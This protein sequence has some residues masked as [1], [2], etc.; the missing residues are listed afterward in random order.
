MKKKPVFLLLLAISLLFQ[1]CGDIEDYLSLIM[2]IEAKYSILEA[3]RCGDLDTVKTILAKNPDFVNKRDEFGYT[4][5]F[6]AAQS[7]HFELVKFLIARGADLNAKTED[8]ET[9]LHFL[10]FGES[11]EIDYIEIAKFIIEKGADIKIKDDKG[12]TLLHIA[13]YFDLDFDFIKLLI[14]KGADINARSKDGKTPLHHASFFCGKKELIEFLI[15]NMADIHAADNKGRTA[16]HD[17]AFG[18]NVIA[19]S[20]LLEHGLDVN[21]KDL[22]DAAPLHYAAF[23]GNKKVVDILIKNGAKSDIFID[24]ALGKNKTIKKLSGKRPKIVDIRYGRGKTL[25]HESL[26]QENLF[27]FFVLNGADVNAR[28]SEGETP[29]HLAVKANRRKIVEV[30]LNAGAHINCKTGTWGK[31]PLHM[32][33]NE[34]LKDMVDLLLEYGADFRTCDNRG[35]TPLHCLLRFYRE[36]N[37]EMIKHLISKGIDIDIKNQKNKESPLNYLMFPLMQ[38]RNKEQ[39][40]KLVKFFIEKGADVNTRDKFN[41]TPLHKAVKYSAAAVVLILLDNKAEINCR[42][43]NGDTPLHEAARPILVIGSQKSQRIE[44]G[45]KIEI[46]RLL[47]SRGAD[48]HAKNNKGQTPLDKAGESYFEEFISLIR[49]YK[50]K[51]EKDKN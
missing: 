19:V 30:L 26:N 41:E 23:K 14:K 49:E 15:E 28:N 25:L 2:F 42:D 22:Y 36:K 6:A 3:C 45:R 10:I 9:L 8:G 24:T 33:V 38:N 43:K 21:R 51:Q 11:E 29:L 4:P 44:L 31:T 40:I 50:N 47:I 27:K 5:I 7:G 32:A 16:L 20:M 18:G 13:A 35:Q 48:I 46:A 39:G 12:R 34:G 37:L 17:A 1:A